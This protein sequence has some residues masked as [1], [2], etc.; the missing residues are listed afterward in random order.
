M[1]N[2]DL[3]ENESKFFNIPYVAWKISILTKNTYNLH[4]WLK[5]YKPQ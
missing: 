5:I 3:T 2:F 4:V 1:I